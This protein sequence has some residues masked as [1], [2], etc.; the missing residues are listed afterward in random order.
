[1]A[2]R[3]RA[4]ESYHAC[5]AQAP[6]VTERHGTSRNVAERRGTSRNVAEQNPRQ[7]G[8]HV[9]GWR[10]WRPRPPSLQSAGMRRYFPDFDT[11][12]VAAQAADVVPVY[13]QLLADRLTPVSAFQL[14]GWGAAG[15]PAN[16]H[17]FL[18][19]SVVGGE[20]I[21]RYSFIATSP[22]LVYQ[23][24]GGRATVTQYGGGPGPP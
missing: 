4:C 15:G 21:A 10:F 17:G 18:L 22:S 13:R 20:K 1:M 23:V 14:L 6:A 24:A 9:A 19:E 16:E 2:Q 8:G 11:F 5:T 7:A 3:P 12:A